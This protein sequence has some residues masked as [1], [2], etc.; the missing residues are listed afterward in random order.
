MET[1][2]RLF[3]PAHLLILGAI[4]LI[5]WAFCRA[6]RS[7]APGKRA[8]RILLGSFLALNELVWYAF[9]Y[10]Q[11]GFRF[12]EGLPLQL[13]DLALW[14]TVVASLRLVRLAYETAYFAGLGGSSMAL[15][16]PDLWAPFPSYPTIYFFLSHG[17]VV[18]TLLVLTGTGVVQPRRGA[19]WRVFGVLNL[20]TAFVACFNAV[21]RTNYMYLCQKPASASLFDYFGPWPMY[22]VVGQLFALAVFWLLWVPVRHL[23]ADGHPAGP[24]APTAPR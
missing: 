20:F 15:L 19:V 17:F 12:P 16:T 3:G 10:S 23:V 9:R 8:L 4:P 14:L 21:F 22:V 6:V 5:A 1:G 2:F 11:E 7:S 18:I 13:C 24:G